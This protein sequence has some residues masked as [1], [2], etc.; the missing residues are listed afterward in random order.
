MRNLID[1]LAGKNGVGCNQVADD[2]TCVGF[3][4]T[5][6]GLVEDDRFDSLRVGL[7]ADFMLTDR[8]KFTADAAYL[9]W[10][11]FTGQDDHNA[12]QLLILEAGGPGDGVMLEASLDYKLTSSWSVGIGGR[13]WA[14]NMHDGTEYFD[15][16][17]LAPP[18]QPQLGRF[19]AERYGFFLQSDYHWGAPSNAVLASPP[20]S[21]MPM[22]WT[23]MFVGGFIG[24]G[25]SDES[26]SDPFGATQRSGETN[27]PG[28]G[29]TIH[30][31]GPL[32]GAQIGANWQT[33]HLVLGI[34]GEGSYLDLRGEN[35]CFSGL[36]G[37]N[38]Q[39]VINGL[40][41]V[42]GRAGF[43]WDR[44]LLYGTGGGAWFNSN[45]TVLG[46][47]NA[48]ALG[49]GNTTLTS[50]GWLVGAGIEY[51]IT[52]HWTTAFEYDHVGVG[53]VT[54][55]FPTVALLRVQNIGVKQ[56]IDMLKLS[57][58]YKFDWPGTIAMR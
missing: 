14:W 18:T 49:Y 1:H 36:G 42:A 47:T 12:R 48:R 25:W 10:V 53:S 33:G 6:Q 30:N 29:D 3:D 5:F 41:S 55:P 21:A 26:W 28:F 31:T 57:I 45:Y 35:T 58:N 50:L 19:S 51:A 24:G 46:N 52:N 7:A 34:K 15:F 44:S 54:V 40:E 2:S 13:Y 16:L 4:P 8:L 39:H 17:G 11:S 32:A 23:G 27:V 9:P 20:A 22:N 56:S 38:C 43:A 37:I